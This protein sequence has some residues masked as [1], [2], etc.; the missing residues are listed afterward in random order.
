METAID[1]IAKTLQM[2]EKNKYIGKAIYDHLDAIVTITDELFD[3]GLIVNL[4]PNVILDR[5]KMREPGDVSTKKADAKPQQQAA[6]G[7]GNAFSSFFGFAKSSL[8]KTLN[9]G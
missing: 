9:L 8:Q 2:I 3:E 6:N 7:G 5:L 1:C 4:D